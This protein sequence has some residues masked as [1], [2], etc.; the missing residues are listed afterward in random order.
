MSKFGQYQLFDRIAIGGMAEIFRGRAAG[1]EGFE[2]QVAIKRILPSYARDGRFVSMLVTEA[3]IHSALTHRNIVQIHDLGVSEDG[4]YFIVL[5]FVD[6]HDLAALLARIAERRKRG[7][8]PAQLS[9]AIALY[10]AIE[11]G[12]GI[13]FA[14]EL[15][16]PDGQPLGLI[17][18]DISPSNVLLS[19]AGEVK[20]SDFGLAK[21][22]TDHSVVGSL[23]GKLAYMSPEQARRA[24]IDRRSDLFALG[25]V[26]Y[27]M[28]T[29]HPLREIED[30]VAGWQ[31]VASGL[32]PPARRVR[33]D[34]PPAIEHLIAK[35]LEPDPRDRYP[36]VRAFVNEA[37]AALE[38]QPRSRLG[39]A[40]ELQSLL[41]ALLPPGTARPARP[42][43]RVIRL[44]SE[45]LSTDT[46]HALGSD[47]TVPGT[48]MPGASKDDERAGTTSETAVVPGGAAEP[49]S[50]TVV[51]PTPAG[52]PPLPVAPTATLEWPR[53]G[54][55]P[56]PPVAASA[57][58]AELAATW[59]PG[60]GI[61]GPM[62][63]PANPGPGSKPAVA[64]DAGPDEALR[65]VAGLIEIEAEAARSAKLP[66]ESQGSDDRIIAAW[67]SLLPGATDAGP[68]PSTPVVDLPA[69][70]A[71]AGKGSGPGLG[72][73]GGTPPLG[74]AGAP[75]S[76]APAPPLQPPFPPA[77]SAPG[78]VRAPID[79]TA[80]EP[81]G[82]APFF[83]PTLASHLSADGP[84]RT[85]DYAH[86][87]THLPLAP[88]GPAG[89]GADLETPLVSALPMS[90][91]PP[92]QPIF[93]A[94]PPPPRRRTGEMTSVVGRRGLG[95]TLG[96]IAL[97]LL[98]LAAGV[99][100]V[101]AVIHV[102]VVPL[103][104]L[105]VWTQ[106]AQLHVR[107]NPRGAEVFLD[108]QRLSAR[109]PT[110]TEVH[111]DRL[112]HTLEIRAEGYAPET[113]QVRFDRAVNLEESLDLRRLPATGVEPVDGPSPG[114][115]LPPAPSAGTSPGPAT[116]ET[117]PAAT[118]PTTGTPAQ[119][120]PAPT[121]TEP[122]RKPRGKAGRGGSTGKT[123]RKSGKAG[124]K[125]KPATSTGQRNPK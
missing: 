50:I 65:S 11:L 4:E 48:D 41:R 37:R 9:D 35:A 104:V 39:E 53:S 54:P 43:S 101:A 23:K 110:Y 76:P 92:G 86:P 66:V 88:R 61:G 10:I 20:L 60:T 13:H 26:L 16:G 87:S 15:A 113:R 89:G 124:R 44:Q 105:V 100:A 6:G 30:S 85:E 12:E 7:S 34:L 42:A 103:G 94:P 123:G 97:V 68:T 70:I 108:G 83:P 114:S 24:P 56:L 69:A 90:A 91:T 67:P 93:Y 84:H 51:A 52:P 120:S 116:P 81:A 19:Y 8:N 25:A 78:P 71:N 112:D 32:V 45:I 33:P 73:D 46:V 117:P 106:P 96:Q 64:G 31:Q 79:P 49:S 99:A 14:H 107:T 72:D 17:H 111:R 21:R 38:D 121:A 36:D 2:K 119:P 102:T 28:L 77:P 5:E 22:R 118:S 95:R 82:P 115:P 55:P 63:T 122:A 109:T 27:E 40:G 98:L 57:R 47:L 3:R 75:V 29:G 1:E 125:S 80:P 74:G 59:P 62:T 18:R 58:L